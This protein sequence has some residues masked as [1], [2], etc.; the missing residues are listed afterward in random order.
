[1]RRRWQI[2]FDAGDR[3]HD[4]CPESAW[5]LIDVLR[6]GDINRTCIP[7]LQ[8]A[9]SPTLGTSV[10]QK[11][12]AAE[13]ELLRCAE[14][15]RQGGLVA[16]P[17]ETVY[18]LGANAFN[19]DAVAKIFELKGRPRFDPLIVHIAEPAQIGA[20]V[21]HVPQLARELIDRFW[22][23]PLSLV[24]PKNDSVPDIVT[25]GLPSVAIRCPA[26]P[27]ARRLIEL[28]GSPIAAPSANLFCTVSP[29]TAQH[30]MDQ[31]GDR[32]PHVID[33]GPCPVGVESAVVSFLGKRPAL[34]RPGGVS[35]EEIEAVI[36]SL[37]IATA[38][39]SQPV[40]PGQLPRHY[41]P[42]TPLELTTAPPRPGALVGLLTFGPP[43]SRSGF[44]AVEVLSE[45]GCL[46]EAAANLFAAMRRLDALGLD[47]IIARPLPEKGLG[48]A[49]MDRLRRAAA[50]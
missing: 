50:K 25:A 6:G 26:H 44:A 9:T 11:T 34:L 40:S 49:V 3:G 24:L 4:A 20:L 7:R 41:A 35:A 14:I 48:Y 23:G 15:I 46:R 39:G 1:M 42:T 47:Y 28:A 37:E 27:V 16:F 18:G 36:G 29:T 10:N 13:H 45:R 8:L 12:M 32:L 21:A 5:R 17:T 33:G 43:P 2:G 19:A 22:P 38:G 31:F 30:V